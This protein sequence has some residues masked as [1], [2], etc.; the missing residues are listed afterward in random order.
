MERGGFVYNNSGTLTIRNSVFNGKVLS[1]NGFVGENSGTVRVRGSMFAPT[2]V[3][4]NYSGNAY[5]SGTVNLTN[6]Y[7]TTGTGNGATKAFEFTPPANTKLAND[8]SLLTF[9]GVQYIAQGSNLKLTVDAAQFTQF[10]S[11]KVDGNDV[12]G[13]NGVYTVTIGD[14]YPAIAAEGRVKIADL[15][16]DDS[17]DSYL[18]ESAEELQALANY[19]SA[20]NAPTNKFKLTHDIDISGKNIQLGTS[21][22][23]FAGEFNGNGYTITTD[24]TLF[25]YT[26]GATIGN[27]TIDGT[28][29]EGSAFIVNADGTNTINDCAFV[30]TLSNATNGFVGNG[31]AN[32]NNSVFAPA[33]DFSGAAFGGTVTSSYYTKGTAGDGATGVHTLIGLPRQLVLTCADAD[34]FTLG[35]TTYYKHGAALTFNRDDETRRV[36][37]GVTV[38]GVAATKDGD[39][40]TITLNSDAADLAVEGS[41]HIQLNG[42]GDTYTNREDNISILGGAGNDSVDNFGKDVTIT[43][44]EGNDTIKLRNGNNSVNLVGFGVGDVIEFDGEFSLGSEGYNESDKKA[45]IVSSYVHTTLDGVKF[46]E[47]GTVWSFNETERTATYGKQK[48]EGVYLDDDGKIK[49]RLNEIKPEDM[50]VELKGIGA[51]FAIQTSNLDGYGGLKA[52]T[53]TIVL[54]SNHFAGGDGISVTSN[55]KGYA[56]ALMEGTGGKHF[57]GSDK[58][59]YIYVEEGGYENEEETVAPV[60]ITSGGGADTI[61]LGL[62]VTKVVVTD[63]SEDDRIELFGTINKKNLEVVDGSLV[64]HWYGGYVADRAVTI[65]GISNIATNLSGWQ[66]TKNGKAYKVGNANGFGADEYGMYIGYVQANDLTPIIEFS[67]LK[68][69]SDDSPRYYNGYGYPQVSL[70]PENFTDNTLAVL[71]QQAGTVVEVGYGDYTG[72][73]LVGSDANYI[74]HDEYAGD[75]EIGDIIQNNGTNLVI[76]CGGGDDSI[77]NYADNAT[78][79]AGS[80]DNNIDLIN[81]GNTSINGGT[82]DNQINIDTNGAVTVNAAQG[83]NTISGNLN[84]LTVENFNSG[85]V[86]DSDYDITNLSISGNNLIASYDGGTFTIAGISQL[87]SGDVTNAWSKSGDTFTYSQSVGTAGAYLVDGN[88]GYAENKTFF[89]LGNLKDGLTEEQIEQGVTINGGKVILSESVLDTSKSPSISGN[90]FRIE[91]DST[92]LQ[93]KVTASWNLIDSNRNIYAYYGEAGD[94]SGWY[95]D[96]DGSWKYAQGIKSL[97]TFENIKTIKEVYENGEWNF[98]DAATID[99]D[100]K[101]LTLSEDSF[102]GDNIE[103]LGNAGGY[104]FVIPDG[105]SFDGLPKIGAMTFGSDAAGNAYYLISTVEDLQALATY[106]N[107][108]NTCAGYTF[109]LADDLD[110]DG[111]SWTPIGSG[112]V[113]YF[114]G[115]FDGQGHIIRNL[116]VETS[117][118]ARAG[119]FG[120]LG[121]YNDKGGTIQNVNLINANVKS[122]R[123]GG[124]VG[125]NYGTIDNCF[126]DGTIENNGKNDALVGAI[127][128]E[129]K[130][131]VTDCYYHSNAGGYGTPVYKLSLADGVTANHVSGKSKTVDGTIYYLSGATFD[132]MLD[133]DTLDSESIY[134]KIAV[135]NGTQIGDNT[136]RYTVYDKDSAQVNQFTCYPKIDGL[137]FIANNNGGGSYNL[138]NAASFASLADFL[139][140]YTGDKSILKFNLTADTYEISDA[141]Q[142]E[143]L[144]TIVNGGNDCKGKTFKLTE[145][146]NLSSIANWTP[147][148]NYPNYFN[149][150]FDGDG[151]TISNLTIN[152]GNYGGYMGLF[153]NLDRNGT[154]KN[155]TLKDVNI[156]GGNN[157]GGIVSQ[158]YGTI[159]NC[160]VEGTISGND[161]FI[162]GIA[163]WNQGTIKNCLTFAKTSGEASVGAIAG[164]NVGT[165]NNSYRLGDATPDDVAL[166]YE[167]T[168]PEG[169]TVAED[170]GVTYNGKLY[171]PAGDLKLNISATAHDDSFAKITGIIGATDNEDGT[172]TY[173]MPESNSAPQFSGLPVIAG[174]TFDATDDS[175][176]IDSVDALQTLRNYVNDGHDCAGLAFK[177]TEEINLDSIANWT[178]I[179]NADNSFAGTFDGGGNTINNLTITSGDNVGLFGYVIG[180]TI[181]NVTLINANVS[182]GNNVS[183]VVSTIGE[184]STVE[185]CFADVILS[186]TTSNAGAIYSFNIDD[187]GTIKDCFYHM[188][189]PK[190]RGLLSS[191]GSNNG[192]LYLL[193]ELE[194]FSITNA[195]GFRKFGGRLYASSQA[196][197]ELTADDDRRIVDSLSI[198]GATIEKSGNVYTVNLTADSSLNAAYHIQLHDDGDSY[199]NEEN[200]ISVLGGAGDDTITNSG[201]NV[202]IDGGA[203]NDSISNTGANV[204]IDVSKGNDTIE[205]EGT[206]SLSVVGFGAGDVIKPA[207][208]NFTDLT[209]TNDGVVA[210]YKNND[211]NYDRRITISGLNLS[212]TVNNWSLESGTASLIP[213][214]LAG[215]YLNDGTIAYHDESAGTAQVAISGIANLDGLTDVGT[216]IELDGSSVNDSGATVGLNSGAYQFNIK[217]DWNGKTFTA[218]DNADV[219]NNNAS[220]IVIKLGDGDD[221][222][223]NF[224]ASDVTITTGGGSDTIE[225]TGNVEDVNITDFSSDDRL[226]FTAGISDYSYKDG[227]LTVTLIDNQ[228]VALTGLTAPTA[229]TWLSVTGGKAAYGIPAGIE[230]SVENKAITCT[231]TETIEKFELSGIADGTTVEQVKAAVDIDDTTITI[232]DATILDTAATVTAPS[233]CTLALG[234]NVKQSEVKTEALTLDETDATKYNY[235]SAGNTEGWRLVDNQIVHYDNSVETFTIS[236]LGNG[237]KLGDNVIISGKTIQI[238][239]GALTASHEKI[240]VDDS[241]YTLQLND[242]LVADIPFAQDGNKVTL[243]G[244]TAG[245]KNVNGAYEW[246]AQVGGEEITITGLKDGATLTAD[247]FTRDGNTITF[248]PTDEV[249]DATTITISNGVIDTSALTTTAKVDAHWD[250]TTY[251]SEQTA[252]SWTT[253]AATVTYTEATGGEELFT[254]N[255]LKAGVTADDLT[256]A[257]DVDGAT[258]KIKSDAIFDTGKKVTAP[259]GYAFKLVDTNGHYVFHDGNS[260]ALATTDNTTG[261]S[262]LTRA[263]EVTLPEGVTVTSGI[264]A[265][266]DGKTYAAGEITLSGTK[267]GYTV[268]S[269]ATINADTTITPTLDDTKHYIFGTEGNYTIATADN[270]KTNNY[271]DLTQVYK[272]TVP[273]GVNV[274]SD[275]YE[276]GTDIYVAANAQVTIAATD[277]NKIIKSATIEGGTLANGVYTLTATKDLSITEPILIWNF[278]NIFTD[279]DG[280]A[281]NPYILDTTTKLGYLTDNVSVGED[282]S[283]KYFKLMSGIGSD[284]QNIGDATNQFKGTATLGARVKVSF[285]DGATIE[286]TNGEISFNT[287]TSTFDSLDNGDKFKVG[288]TEYTVGDGCILQSGKVW[289]NPAQVTIDGLNTENN[290]T[291]A[292]DGTITLSATNETIYFYGTDGKKVASF[293]GSTLTKENDSSTAITTIDARALTSA[294]TINGFYNEN[295]TITAGTSGVNVN[296]GGNKFSVFNGAFKF[297]GSKLIDGTATLSTVNDAV[298]V[299]DNLITLT[300]G[301]GIT[302]NATTS[303]ISSLNS[304]DKFKIDTDSYEVAANGIIKNNSAIHATAESLAISSDDWTAATIIADDAITL[305][306]DTTYVDSTAKKIAKLESGTLTAFD[307]TEAANLTVD[308]GTGKEYTLGKEFINLKSGDNSFKVTATGDYKVNGITITL[309]NITGVEIGGVNYSVDTEKIS[310]TLS[311]NTYHLTKSDTVTT[312]ALTGDDNWK[313]YSGTVTVT[314]SLTTTDGK[315][316]TVAGDSDGVEVAVAN[317]SITSITGLASSGSVTYDGKTYTHTIN[318]PSSATATGDKLVIDGKDY[319]A[320]GTTVTIAGFTSGEIS[321]DSS[322]TNLAKSG[323]SIVAK[324]GEDVALI[325]S[326]L[327]YP[328]ENGNDWTVGGNSASYL[329]KFTAGATISNGKI[330]YQ[331]E[332][333]ETLFTL[334]N[335]KNNVTVDEVKSAIEVDDGKKITIK[336]STILENGAT[337]NVDNDYSVKLS[338]T[339]APSNP[340]SAGWDGTSYYSVDGYKTTGWTLTNGKVTQVNAATPAVTVNGVKSS[341]GLSL[342]GTTVTVSNAA[343]NQATVTISDGYSLVLGNDVTKSSTTNADWTFA[344]NVA[345]YKAA[346]S[347]A[348]YKLADNKISYV[349]ASGGE[350]LATVTGVKSLDGVSLNGKVVTVSNASLNGKEVTISGNGYSLALGTD[351][352]KT[353]TT[354]AGWT[355]ANNVA[356]YKNSSTSAGYKLADNKISYVAAN[357]GETLATVTGVKSLDGIS[358]NGKVVTVSNAALDGKEVTISGNGYS[359]ALGT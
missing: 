45:V 232:N 149:G 73:T 31:T 215:A 7:Y 107:A 341:D 217:S 58:G 89:T 342:N 13:Q 309:A 186:S 220:N 203:G 227:T 171:V 124:I 282:Y 137:K 155:L 112:N 19:I 133:T 67:G 75:R 52:G 63:M 268:T 46:S 77:I 148:G 283:G 173:T 57:T 43:A 301:D 188:D 248:K 259:N 311:G 294:I 199:T 10:A 76:M 151:H 297:D 118:Y 59:E 324:V 147:I 261:Y 216:V 65:G 321:F 88:I 158:N 204:S 78:I 38:G 322:I 253:N 267:T 48:L 87:A 3:P 349:A 269:S 180:G 296:V 98:Y 41:W 122:N 209:V 156:S 191:G 108:G 240:S 110:L 315:T 42:K 272:V 109:K 265:T 221:K 11:F 4:E 50:Y 350:T 304:G 152:G 145:D 196:Q 187:L 331:S 262:N 178:P 295:T 117:G 111:V 205:F 128:G 257:I 115:T 208:G 245:Y 206:T 320:T 277:D 177:Q 194:H 229:A 210:S 30:G 34:K 61:K 345:S 168:L 140:N 289:L 85:D 230:Y 333:T 96:D 307:A 255:N 335:S 47:D 305:G 12:A 20:G 179:G 195:V 281:N 193:T 17:D 39:A 33:G 256:A 270:V 358:L 102:N 264:F 329:K 146:I 236:G 339:L 263:Y 287:S 352:T 132:L 200:N 91:I 225:I 172:F 104:T 79:I 64:A 218:T 237:A 278:A 66:D 222:L 139:A 202:T 32:I 252:S 344:N 164:Y 15:I 347:S 292:V 249:I 150:T 336:G 125:T 250:G 318:L 161:R 101:V 56:F 334:S 36:V 291:A 49:Y 126:V 310:K 183:A 119:L 182:G 359:L 129:N 357:G 5:A 72:K 74:Q 14:T 181:K 184:G 340:V 120:D 51:N 40:Y 190:R 213:T 313:L 25:N 27:L 223:V 99:K 167:L 2:T 68:I 70:S 24:K 138:D 35:N 81:G 239:S 197:F 325:I 273:E 330:T 71:Q 29:A 136:Y 165:I 141:A 166:A 53:E 226:E 337:I 317:G 332:R 198:D 170:K 23:K 285:N 258:I 103:L 201:N 113:R 169:V 242:S 185:N 18:I 306:N 219:I 207:S 275:K 308:V 251:V 84:S 130:G 21:G 22:Y 260:Y 80:G 274:T 244:T 293:D 162:G 62:N 299:G 235:N 123:A 90:D 131:T 288:D 26:S 328:T 174:L 86:I 298:K 300:A 92:I 326:G 212:Q 105:K 160:T 93:R 82:G 286:V 97:F 106:V 159:E 276:V 153:K 143:L 142:L 243:S 189:T 175:Y 356:T 163:A 348:G 279:A 323:D 266:A 224:A 241:S 327:T 303:T 95:K 290:W 9:D 319:Y 354:N 314:N 247:I 312:S 233:G 192:A 100:N 254:L 121:Y 44:G 280:T 157:I 346:S 316:L 54:N 302:V 211:S 353:S 94:G 176:I 231:D 238:S 338:S 355:F 1:G 154:I 127:V 351:V 28:I 69:V 284:A 16:Y 8:N 144:A 37:D 135:K 6:S 116:K 114:L 83:N 214:S 246:Q 134:E 234:D 343:L 60:T 228:T 271:P 55:E